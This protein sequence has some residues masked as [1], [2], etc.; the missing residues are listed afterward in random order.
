MDLAAEQLWQMGR[1]RRSIESALES[2][3][4]NCELLAELKRDADAYR[5]AL[6]AQL[7]IEDGLISAR[8]W[9]TIKSTPA[10]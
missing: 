6:A 1:H 8:D 7:T 5:V 2:A 9:L 3:K 10:H 4:L